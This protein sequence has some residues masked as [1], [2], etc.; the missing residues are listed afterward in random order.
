MNKSVFAAILAG[1]AVCAGC[2]STA[3]PDPAMAGKR[4]GVYDSR[5][6]AVAFAG[7]EKH[8]ASL[9]GLDEPAMRAAQ[10]TMHE[11]GFSTAP[12]DDI[13]ALY[14]DEIAALK[15]K[16]NLDALVSKWDKSTL[17]R[18]AGAAQIDVTDELIEFPK[19]NEQQR[20]SALE[21]KQHK[22]ISREKARNMKH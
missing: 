20:R 10:A 18:Y 2:T 11:Q 17:D 14:S 9:R 4:I 19:P 21:I 5:C 12:V 22:P 1:I 7:S 3:K 8:E 13:L 6:V 15:T 16:H